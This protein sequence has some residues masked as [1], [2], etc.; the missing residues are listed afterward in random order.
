MGSRQGA[1]QPAED[2]LAKTG[3]LATPEVREQRRA[4]CGSEFHRRKFWGNIE[5]CESDSLPVSRTEQDES[6]EC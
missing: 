1:T 6:E 3:T 4:R 2:I 5:K